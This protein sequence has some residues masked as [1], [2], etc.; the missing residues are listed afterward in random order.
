MLRAQ[1]A[2]PALAPEADA[3]ADHWRAG[4]TRIRRSD[5]DF[6]LIAGDARQTVPR[7]TGRADAWFLD[8][9][10]PARNP[11]MWEPALLQAVAD[12]TAPGGTVATYTAAGAVRR[13]L[14][15]AGLEV[16]RVPGYGRKRHMTTARRPR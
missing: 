8:G 6:T 5:L 13:A 3:L 14:A 16:A 4:E 2:F 7:W 12:R 9:F 15:D 1:A 10:A 11:Q